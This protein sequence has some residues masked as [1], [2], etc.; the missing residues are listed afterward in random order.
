MKGTIVKCLEE[1]VISKYGKDKWVRSLEDAGMDPLAIIWPMGDI[2]DAQVIEL[3][4]AVCQN[5]GISL[6]QAA[7]AFGD[8]WVNVYAQKMYQ[9]YFARHSTAKG[10]L[11][12]M[13]KVH[14]EMTRNIEKARPPRFEFEWKDERTLIMTYHSH[15]GLL[16]F[17]VGLAKG[18]GRFYKE[19]LRV[20]KLEP[21]QVK[22]VFG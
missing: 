2:P 19:N 9:M 13:N 20:T 8:Y 12:A 3:V 17:V 4:K 15:R 1:L 18:V 16:D 6:V 10:F 11:Q 14:Q 7:D 21:N 5:L 22:I